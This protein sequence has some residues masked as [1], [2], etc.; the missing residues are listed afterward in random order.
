MFQFHIAFSLGLIA[1]SAGTVLF[2]WSKQQDSSGFAKTIG[3]LII[4]FSITSTLCTVYY[5]IK[6]WQQGSFQSPMSMQQNQ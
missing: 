4:I 3:V 5:G 1:L 6:Y 2:S